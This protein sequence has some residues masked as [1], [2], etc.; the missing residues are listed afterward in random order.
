MIFQRASADRKEAEIAKGKFAHADG[1][2]LTLL[3]VYHAYKGQQMQSNDGAENWC[4]QNY[5]NFRNLK[6]VD[7]VAVQLRRMMIKFG[8]DFNAKN[9]FGDRS[10]YT[11]IRKCILSGFFMQIAHLEGKDKYLTIKDHQ[12]VN[13]HPSSELSHR[14]EWVLYNEYVLTK[15]SWIRTVTEV[16]AEWLYEVGSSVAKSGYFELSQIPK[17]SIKTALEKVYR[18]KEKKNQQLN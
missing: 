6:S 4:Y 13:I 10:Y 17:G 11:N 3:N 1:D 8:I 2:H 9:P 5:L 7:N 15:K 16:K 18:R 12:P 14:P